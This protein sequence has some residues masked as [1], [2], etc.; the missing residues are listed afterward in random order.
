MYH[1]PGCFSRRRWSE[2]DLFGWGSIGPC[3]VLESL[4]D[5]PFRFVQGYFGLVG[6]FI[7]GWLVDNPAQL[8]V[9]YPKESQRVRVFVLV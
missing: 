3:W 1:G 5:S 7:K 9:H 6:H 4:E 8:S 2:L